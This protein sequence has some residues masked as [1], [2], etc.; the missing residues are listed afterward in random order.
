MATRSISVD[1]LLAADNQSQSAQKYL[2]E[3]NPDS[4]TFVQALTNIPS[5]AKQFASDIITPFL[6]PIKTAKT[7]GQLVSGTVQLFTD[8]EQENEALARAVG[9]F[10]KQRYGS[11]DNIKQTLA[12]DPVGLLSDLSV[13][14]TGGGTLAAKLPAAAGTVGKVA[15]TVGKVVDPVNV[16]AKGV[17]AASPIVSK[18]V[19][20]VFGLTTGAGG[21]AVSEA[22]Q[23][24]AEGGKRADTFTD[25][26]R[27]KVDAE[28]VV[29]EAFAGMKAIEE[30]S[31]KNYLKGIDELELGKQKINFSNIEK[32]INDLIEGKKFK[33]EFTVSQNAVN[34]IKSIK[35]IVARWKANKGLHNAKGIDMLKRKI[36]AEYP[37]G[38]KV[39]DSGVIVTQ[40]RNKVKDALVKEVPNYSKVMKK[41]EDAI[42]LEQKLK[43]ELGMGNKKAAG[44]ILRKL[45][46]VMRDNVN[47]N[48]GKRFDYVKQLDDAGLNTN[49]MSALA[50]QSLGTFTPRGLQG[51]T[52]TGTGVAAVGGMIDPF[53]ASPTTFTRLFA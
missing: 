33:G 48:F 7:I 13:V 36:D 35:E 37:T 26:L 30:K 45:Q 2:N 44:T 11:L 19:S 1:D 21:R 46:S 22:F 23:S 14:L 40:I 17:A 51:L 32:A 38:L 8:G 15:S 53:T 29:D 6:S 10:Y 12:T 25:N 31:K 47:T 43:K 24:G 27:G 5:S 50:G 41:Y 42:N 16:A 52:T 18:P 49:I 4:N 9:D 3:F 20:Q 39:G 34:K 28:N